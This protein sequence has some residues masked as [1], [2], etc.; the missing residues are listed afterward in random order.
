[1]ATQGIG[2]RVRRKEGARHLEGRGRFVGSIKQPRSLDVAFLGSPVEDRREHL[3]AG[4]NARQHHDRITA[5]ADPRAEVTVDTGAYSV[6][7]FTACLEA[8][9]AGGNLPGT[10]ILPSYR[11]RTYSAA[12]SKPPDAPH[13]AGA[14]L[15]RPSGRHLRRKPEPHAVRGGAGLRRLVGR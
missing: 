11:R 13:H 8:A 2:A 7:P 5:Y 10:C 6:W 14:E 4:A 15:R 9:P 3:T 1:M 12:T